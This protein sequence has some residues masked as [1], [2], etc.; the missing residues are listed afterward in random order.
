MTSAGKRLAAVLAAL[1]LALAL[2]AECFLVLPGQSEHEEGRY[3]GAAYSGA[4]S[5]SVAFNTATATED[6]CFVLGSSELAT[7][8]WMVPQAPDAVFSA[9]DD[10]LDV[11]FIGE[12]YDQSLWHAIAA[13]AMDPSMP[14]KKLAFIVSPGWFEDA[15][16]E[17][18]IFKLRFSYNLYE[19]MCANPAISEETKAYVR[20]RLAQEG[21]ETSV[22]ESTASPLPQNAINRLIYSGMADLYLRNSLQDVRANAPSR[23]DYAP[24]AMSGFNASDFAALREQARADGA[25]WCTNNDYFVYDE[26][27]STYIEPEYEQLEGSMVGETFSNEKEFADFSC[28]LDI[29]EECGIDP[30]VIVMPLNGAWYDYAGTDPADR[31][32]FYQRIEQMCADRGVT[33]A[34]YG[35]YEYEPYFMRDIMHFGWLGWAQVDEDLWNY[36]KEA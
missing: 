24:N 23:D 11:C 1:A 28:F 7:M 34:N 32:A 12:A 15:G 29:C 13:G 4:K 21:V 3:Y 26:Y 16:L 30:L 14:D 10:G 27:W 18:G 5:E 2:L 35:S 8:P 9:P 17:P 22:I 19:G 36:A 6:T 33:C 31:E 25:S 20:E